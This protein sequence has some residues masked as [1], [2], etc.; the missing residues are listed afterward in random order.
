M[1]NKH[2][3]KVSDEDKIEH[4]LNKRKYNWIFSTLCSPTY[5]RLLENK[6]NKI[7]I[8]KANFVLDLK[9]HWLLSV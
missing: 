5:Y 2:F 4:L 8:L 9:S 6:R 1:S 3:N 7:N